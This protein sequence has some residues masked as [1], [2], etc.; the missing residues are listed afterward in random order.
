M[1]W[2]TWNPLDTEVYV[3]LIILAVG[4]VVWLTRR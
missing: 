3:L 4:C 2:L 1:S